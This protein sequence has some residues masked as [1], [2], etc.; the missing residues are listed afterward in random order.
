MLQSSYVS[1]KF[2]V[3]Q[4]WMIWVNIPHNFLRTGYMTTPEH[5]KTKPFA[6]FSKSVEALLSSSK[7][8]H[9]I[10]YLP[11]RYGGYFKYSIW[12]H[13]L[14]INLLSIRDKITLWWI[15]QVFTDDKS[16]L[17]QVMAYCYIGIYGMTRP[18]SLSISWW[19][20]THCFPNNWWEPWFIASNIP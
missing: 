6:C 1:F 19:L 16:T 11:L 12:Q 20:V 18:Q 13:I 5:N 3:K 7:M 8:T 15:P 14:M 10:T 4:P 9:P 2:S 17:I